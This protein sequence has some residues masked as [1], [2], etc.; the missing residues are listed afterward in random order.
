ME[1]KRCDTLLGAEGMRALAD[2]RVPGVYGYYAGALSFVEYLVA[3]RGVGGI[4]DLLAQMAETGNTEDAFRAVHGRGHDEMRRQW[5][6]RL[7]Q[8]YGS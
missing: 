1:G 5:K 4:N 8:Q 6:E 7:K 2:G 3:L